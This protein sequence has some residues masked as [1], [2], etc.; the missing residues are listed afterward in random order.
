MR[1]SIVYA[2]AAVL[3]S[4]TTIMTWNHLHKANPQQSDYTPFVASAAV[5]PELGNS[6]S[7]TSKDAPSGQAPAASSPTAQMLGAN[8]DQ[9]YVTYKVQSG[10]TIEAIAANY[11]V[12]T[13]S[14]L[15]SNG[16]SAED[17]IQIDQELL[18]PTTDGV[19]YEIKAD[20]TLWDVAQDYSVTVSD[21]AQANPEINPDN[22][23][24]GQVIVIPGGK[25]SARG[26]LVASRG[27]A[28]ASHKV[29]YWPT[30]GPITDDFG[31]RIH[32]V[33]GTKS[34]HDGM[35]IGVGVGTPVRAALG[36]TVTMAS[37][38]GGYGLTVRVDHGGGLATEY[39]HLSKAL[40]KVGDTVE[41][42]E[43]IAYSGNTGVSTGPHLHFMVLEDGTPTDP[44]SW[45]P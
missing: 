31:W 5:H 11:G 7:T 3:V 32:P 9:K 4:G 36:G 8:K 18:V 28:V 1:R 17:T 40:V 13:E 24:S 33:Y 39:A 10:D 27:R 22:L 37:Y 23:Q 43:N 21:I 42:G 6:E 29:S 44:M 14:I 15:D 12:S 45:L 30:V 2:T 35:D 26:R 34:F 19:V 20:D 25:L 41:A 16:L 38:N